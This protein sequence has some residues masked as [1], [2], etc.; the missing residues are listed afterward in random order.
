M[1]KIVA[2]M[3][4]MV[5]LLPCIVA[6]K[7][8]EV[9]E[10][11]TTEP[12]VPVSVISGG[13]SEYVIVYS[14]LEENNMKG[15]YQKYAELMQSFINLTTK[16]KLEVMSDE[17]ATVA[18]EIVV[19]P[20]ARADRY[21]SPVSVEAYQK[22]YSLFISDEK[23]VLEAGS[24]I[25]LKLGMFEL[26]KELIG[27]D[28]LVDSKARPEEGKTEFSLMSDFAVSETFVSETMPYMNFDLSEFGVCFNSSN[29]NQRR[30]AVILQ[31]EVKGADKVIMERVEHK[32]AEEGKAYF[33]FEE[34]STVASGSF[35]INTSGTKITIYAKDYY[36]YI[37][38]ARAIVKLRKDMGFYPFR[39][40]SSNQGVHLDYLKAHEESSKYVYNNSSEYRVMFY[41]VYWGGSEVERGIL[42][43]ELVLEYM[44]DVIGFQ[45]FK[46]NR[47]SGIVTPLNK[48]NKGVKTPTVVKK[49][50]G[51]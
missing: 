24:E 45:E 41:N 28:L 20:L 38:A 11:T 18:K 49:P 37:S 26:L 40:G 32:W 51:L 46:E 21:T 3:L 12:A 50:R 30:A 25:G 34:D 27:V 8:D 7:K 35:R 44:P 4:V 29:Y 10:E 1:K 19:G 6:C 48:Y 31:Q 13:A 22:G 5:M 16:A 47:L 39:E 17:K 2:L 15:K 23:I 14:T 36:G 42:Q 9:P 33:W 43:S